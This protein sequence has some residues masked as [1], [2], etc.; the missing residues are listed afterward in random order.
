MMDID[1]LYTL[2]REHPVISTDSRNLPDGCIFFAL[3]GPNFDG[4]RFA[5]ESLAQGAAYAITDDPATAAGN[6][7]LILVKNVLECLQQLANYHRRK[8]R[9]P[10]IAITGTNGKTTTKELIATVLRRKYQV[11]ATQGNLN[12]HIG[13]P[14]TLLGMDSKTELSIIEM[15]AN[16]PG[17]IAAL[18]QIAEP[19]YGIIT[20]IGKAH[21]EGFG[22]FEGV[23]RTK[24][25]LYGFLRDNGG[26]C[27]INTDNELLVRQAAG[28]E[29][30]SFGTTGEAELRGIPEE[31]SWYLT[32]RALFPKGW[33]YLRSKL[34]GSYNF[35]NILAAA[36][37]GLHFGVGPT[38]I[39][40]AIELYEPGNNRSQLMQK[41][42][43]RIIMDAYNANP[44]SMTAALKNFAAISHPR[45]VLILGDMLELGSYA[46]EE[47]QKI[48]DL[49][50]NEDLCSVFLVGSHFSTVDAASAIKF[51][52]STQLAGYLA[53]QKPLTDSLILIKGSR[54]I[55]LEKVLEKLDAG[56]GKSCQ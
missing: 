24:S 21:L 16:H 36:R 53:S 7:R 44:T 5:A 40:K 19:D 23:V 2:F 26:K 56:Q 27:F 46:R 33:L 28:L 38:D 15:G 30:L 49:I 22:S 4:N 9:V 34:V 39:Q 45:K 8:L 55:Q 25:E 43:N 12:N 13:V 35:E 18:C 32:V 17:E 54:G 11:T 14:V 3:K 52:T 51:E 31:G 42:S 10:V 41:G 47:H 1:D 37:I 48:A 50:K 6:P 20:N 29:Q